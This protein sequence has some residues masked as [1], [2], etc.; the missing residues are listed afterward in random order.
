[1]TKQKTEEVVINELMTAIY[2]LG[3]ADAFDLYQ[4]ICFLSKKPPCKT[5]VQL[6]LDQG[7]IPRC[8]KCVPSKK[9]VNN[10]KRLLEEKETKN[11]VKK[12]TEK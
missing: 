5:C 1:M 11:H 8:E 12:A 3:K 10:A 4:W 2:D 9:L 6:C 7:R